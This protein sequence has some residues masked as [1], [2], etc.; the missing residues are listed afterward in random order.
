MTEC[1][2]EPVIAGHFRRDGGS[3]P[4]L[5]LGKGSNRRLLCPP[6]GTARRAMQSGEAPRYQLKGCEEAFAA[7][8]KGDTIEPWTKRLR[9]KN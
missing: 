9:K 7:G 2:R 5:L 6:P 3:V 4:T 1:L 8:G